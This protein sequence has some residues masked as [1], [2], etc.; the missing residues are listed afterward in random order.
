MELLREELKTLGNVPEHVAI[1]MDGNGR[2]AKSKG[3]TVKDGHAAGVKAAKEAV[4]TA[5]NAGVKVLTLYTF[6]VQNWKRPEFEIGALM[7]LL[8]ESA[9][10]EVAEL[11]R[12]GVK[13]LVSGD[14]DGLPLAQ[15]KALKMVINKT[16]GSDKLILNLA[17][18]YG[19]REEIVR[20]ARLIAKGVKSGDVELDSID[21]K[22]FRKH[23]YTANIPDPDLLIRTSGELRI[24]NFLL[25]QIAY[26]EFYITDVFWPNFN[27]VEFYRALVEYAK[28]NRRFGGR[29]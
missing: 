12:E 25:W 28:R 6:S 14:L 22:L 21:E 8:S 16:S 4:K 9:F 19:A 13:V 7:R 1:I 2:W 24:S 27:E 17:L 18:N 10:G 5:R 29:E 15:R 26:T 11:K 23:L 3:L 20:A